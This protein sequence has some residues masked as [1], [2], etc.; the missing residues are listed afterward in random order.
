M[1]SP[2]LKADGKKKN[3]PLERRGPTESDFPP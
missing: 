2:L 1:A 3:A